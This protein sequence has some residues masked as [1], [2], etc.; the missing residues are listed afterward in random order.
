MNLCC[1]N[2]EIAQWMVNT[3]GL[4]TGIPPNHEE[5]SDLAQPSFKKALPHTPLKQSSY[6]K[7]KHLGNMKLN[8]CVLNI[9]ITALRFL[10]LYFL[11]HTGIPHLNF[12]VL[13]GKVRK[14]DL[15]SHLGMALLYVWIMQEGWR[16]TDAQTS[17]LL[18]SEAAT[19]E[20]S[21]LWILHELSATRLCWAAVPRLK[22]LRSCNRHALSVT[23]FSQLMVRHLKI[24]WDYQFFGTSSL[25]E[26]QC[27]LLFQQHHPKYTNILK[28][29]HKPKNDYMYS[30]FCVFMCMQVGDIYFYS[31]FH[32][33]HCA[34]EVLVVQAHT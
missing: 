16:A 26:F 28:S 11:K 33:S 10:G 22:A 7:H 31:F 3:H 30:Y 12:S 19:W 32:A 29:F 4:L 17:V 15:R 13:L 27:W 6:T 21:V 1:I 34:L 23:S 5:S 18:P 9:Q 2:S 20:T 8:K 25:N 24:L 14:R